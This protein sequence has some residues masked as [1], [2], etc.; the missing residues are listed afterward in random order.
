MQIHELPSGTLTSSDVTAIDN[1]TSTRKYN[2][3]ETINAIGSFYIGE[4]PSEGIAVPSDASG[5]TVINHVT[6]A[7]AG[8]Y[9]IIGR[10]YIPANANGFRTIGLSA[11]SALK[12]YQSST[13]ASAGSVNMYMQVVWFTTVAAN[14]TINLIARQNSGSSLAINSRMTAVRLK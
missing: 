14:A 13:S 7:N 11:D 12:L 1:G 6:L 8:R 2:L 5:A 9:L 4:E 10:A 3:G